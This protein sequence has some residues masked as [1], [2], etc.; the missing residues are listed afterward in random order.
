MIKTKLT[1]PGWLALAALLVISLSCSDDSTSPATGDRVIDSFPLALGNHWEYTL[2]QS[3]YV[4]R[5]DTIFS[6]SSTGRQSITVTRTE[7]IG[8]LESFGMQTTHMI[9]YLFSEGSDTTIEQRY[10]A[11]TTDGR[12]LLKADQAVYN[13]TGGFI[14]FAIGEENI[15]RYGTMIEVNGQEKFISLE[16]LGYLLS[17]TR[18]AL[19]SS[20]QD[21]TLL[22]SDGV[23]ND[24]TAII[25][26]NE[27]LYLYKELYE[28]LRWTSVSA[29]DVNQ[30]DISGRV[31]SILSELDGYDGPIAEV[32]QTNSLIG[33]S[34]FNS[35]QYVQRFY[36]KG[37]V[38][39]IK[40]EISDPEFLIIVQFPDSSLQL[41]TGTWT[42]TKSLSSHH[43]Q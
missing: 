23:E 19:F 27:Y 12:V 37:G 33:A 21:G 28:D 4:E 15:P 29:D 1:Y 43:I 18:G 22:A 3:I 10:F 34:S 30:I 2:Q 36:Y 13:P 40:A 38:G 42:F 24:E 32:A 20:Q 7:N 17:D 41:G 25:Y 26:T 6:L 31:N 35:E 8:G 5:E 39:L 11:P 16:K 14:P 9:D